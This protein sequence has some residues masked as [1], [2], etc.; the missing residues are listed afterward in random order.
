MCVCVCEGE[1]EGAREGEQW[2]EREGE[3][4]A[5]VCFC[6]CCI[7]SVCSVACT[8]PITVLLASVLCKEIWA[9]WCRRA[10]NALAMRDSGELK[11]GL[12]MAKKIQRAV[13][14]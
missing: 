11:H 3:R 9:H 1:G 12:D 6:V 4:H 8:N 14:R 5:C 10:Y 13:L 7:V 2:R